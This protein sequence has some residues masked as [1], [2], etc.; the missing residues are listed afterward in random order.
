MDTTF[1]GWDGFSRL[2][3]TFVF[4]SRRMYSFSGALTSVFPPFSVCFWL[5]FASS[6][7][8]ILSYILLYF[9]LTLSLLDD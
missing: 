8:F 1:V 4:N 9:S 3:A 6:W 2:V 7:Y 5:P